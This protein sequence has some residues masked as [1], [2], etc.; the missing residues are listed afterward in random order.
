MKL[1]ELHSILDNVNVLRTTLG[2]AKIAVTERNFGES[3]VYL[4][5]LDNHLKKFTTE[6]ILE[7]TT[8]VMQ[9]KLEEQEV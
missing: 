9:N 8:Q 6:L 7:K 1:V 5:N 2:K 4:N 3:L